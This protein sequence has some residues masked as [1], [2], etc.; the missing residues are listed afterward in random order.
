VHDPEALEMRAFF[1]RLAPVIADLAVRRQAPN[2]A[3][4]VTPRCLPCV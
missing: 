1:P 2:S 3:W 4:C